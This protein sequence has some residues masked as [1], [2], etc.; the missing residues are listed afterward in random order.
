MSQ[1]AFVARNEA[2][3]YLLMNKGTEQLYA[4][5]TD[6]ALDFSDP[7]L[8]EYES[9]PGEWSTPSRILYRQTSPLR[10]DILCAPVMVEFNPTSACN[11]R[12]HFCYVGDWL[13]SDAVQFPR[14]GIAPFIENMVRAGVFRLIILG[15]EPFLYRHLAPLLDSACGHDL[16]VSLSTN[17]T[18]DRPD[19]WDRLVE[20]GVHLNVS[21]HS[22]LP[23]VEDSIVSRNGAFK[24]ASRAIGALCA[25]G[26]SP[27]VSTVVTA[28]N[29]D[30]IED[31]V[32]FLNN[33]GV[34]NVSLLHTQ[35][36]GSAKL[37]HQKCVSFDQFKDACYRATQRA[38]ALDM[39]VAA[40]T[41][42]P[43]LL[44]EDLSFNLGNG[45]ARFMYGHPDGRRVM[46]VLNDGRVVGTLYQDLRVPLVAG[47]IL[48]EELSEIWA[49]STVLDEIRK[50]KPKQDCLNCQH[51]EYC[52]GGPTGNLRNVDDFSPPNCPRFV[53]QL[54]TE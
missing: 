9:S 13:N 51:F 40:T 39:T 30:K 32:K 38:D 10:P 34:K 8:F 14:E 19:I 49:R 46:Y 42:F 2:F 54:Q 7:S 36:S 33:L 47:N 44:Y 45:L 15:G 23:E 50:L 28:E 20:Y 4:V 26:F 22:H 16:V 24:M 37:A 41:N 48:R 18:V 52:R 35:G 11:E 6:E 29:V 25:R 17:G 31:T 53:S 12:C 21:F 27:H 5:R 3:G 1:Y 43:F